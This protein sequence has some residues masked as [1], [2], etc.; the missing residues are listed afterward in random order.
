MINML[1]SVAYSIL[2]SPSIPENEGHSFLYEGVRSS[3]L[4]NWFGSSYIAD[5]IPPSL[6]PNSERIYLR[7]EAWK[8]VF[9]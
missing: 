4:R 9:V 7:F 1:F 2:K 6:S 8:P 5:G 3:N